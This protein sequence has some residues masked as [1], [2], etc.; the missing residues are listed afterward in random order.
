MNGTML[1]NPWFV[2]T[3]SSAIA[4]CPIGALEENRTLPAGSSR[5]E[6]SFSPSSVMSREPRGCS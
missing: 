6:L 2:A 1:L 3:G 4:T 5:A